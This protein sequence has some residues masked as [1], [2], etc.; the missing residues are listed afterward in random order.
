MQVRR[1]LENPKIKYYC[2][3]ELNSSS[4]SFFTGE[5]SI[6]WKITLSIILLGGKATSKTIGDRAIHRGVIC[7][8]NCSFGP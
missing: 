6:L 3:L 5:K 2:L 1:R 8:H 7:D 4:N